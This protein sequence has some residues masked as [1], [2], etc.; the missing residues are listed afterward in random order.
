M[1]EPIVRLSSLLPRRR[2]VRTQAPAPEQRFVAER[3]VSAVAGN[4]GFTKRQG[5][6][7][8]VCR[9]RRRC[10]L[11]SCSDRKARLLDPT[12]RRTTASGSRAVRR[13]TSRRC[14]RRR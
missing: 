3:H 2:R 7:L 13:V 6:A 8:V 11:S 9:N 1:T 14:L 10:S 4:G 5:T 12:P